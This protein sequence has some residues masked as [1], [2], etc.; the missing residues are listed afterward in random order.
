MNL[1]N[2]LESLRFDLDELTKTKE[3]LIRQ[4]YLQRRKQDTEGQT[5]PL[6]YYSW[7][8]RAL[9]EFDKKKVLE[10]VAKLLNK[11]SSNFVLQ[12]QEVYKVNQ[13]VEE[14]MSE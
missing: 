8:Q 6:V 5:E 2:F 9:L 13:E 10:A 14:V 7:G 1:N 12:H 11:P 3:R 4:L